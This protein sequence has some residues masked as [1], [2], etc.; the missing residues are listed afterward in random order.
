MGIFDKIKDEA[1]EMAEKAQDMIHKKKEN[2]G[3]DPDAQQPDSMDD[4]MQ[5]AQNMINKQRGGQDQ[6]VEDT[7]DSDEDPA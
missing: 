2:Q 6:D 7:L 1:E 3:G 4:P 5:T